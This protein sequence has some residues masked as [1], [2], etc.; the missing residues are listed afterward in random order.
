MEKWQSYKFRIL[1][2]ERKKGKIERIVIS[3]G[4]FVSPLRGINKIY[5]SFFF[6]TFFLPLYLGRLGTFFEEG[7]FVCCLIIH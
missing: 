1:K 2:S 5:L 6:G 3:S 7:F 4:L